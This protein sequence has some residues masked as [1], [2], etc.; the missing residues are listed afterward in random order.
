MLPSTARVPVTSTVLPPTDKATRLVAPSLTLVDI[1][2][3]VKTRDAV[4]SSP[5]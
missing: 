2:V 4:E 3:P 1:V 5:S